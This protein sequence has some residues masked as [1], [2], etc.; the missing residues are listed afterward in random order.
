MKSL[1]MIGFFRE[2]IELC[3]RA[4]YRIFGVVDSTYPECDYTYLGTDEQ[5]LE[6]SNMY[7]HIPI[8]IIPDKPSVRKRL[9]E[10]YINQGFS[11]ETVI[12]PKAY[13]SKSAVINEGCIVQDGCNI[14]SDV[15][16][17]KCVKINTMANIMHD[18][19]V[20]DYST[21][22][23]SAVV[24]GRCNIGSE[25]YI[26]A[27]STILPGITITEGVIVGAGAVVTKNINQRMT[28]VGIPAYK[29][30]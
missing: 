13:V 4:G 8:C 12:S 30:S 7:N 9:C 14:S 25:C 2:T 21:V 3:E 28:V 20:A 1:I 17:G 16:L 5:V 19:V 23:P 27:N 10:M 22:A 18:S 29:L 26:G 24:L 11:L 15:V 6:Q